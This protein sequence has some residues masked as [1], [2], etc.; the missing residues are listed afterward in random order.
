[1]YLYISDR[2][3]KAI[4]L[5]ADEYAHSNLQ[6]YTSSI[7]YS[8]AVKQKWR[9][10]STM[11]DQQILSQE[12]QLNKELTKEEIVK[13]INHHLQW[14]DLYQFQSGELG[15][16]LSRLLFFS[17]T[18]KETASASTDEQVALQ[19]QSMKDSD[20]Q[21]KKLDVLLKTQEIMHREVLFN[22]QFY[23]FLAGFMALKLKNL[24]DKIK[25][26][27]ELWELGQITEA[28]TDDQF[29]KEKERL[30]LEEE[31][32]KAEEARQ[33]AEAFRLAEEARKQE[34]AKRLAEASEEEKLKMA[35]AKAAEEEFI[36]QQ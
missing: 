17:T 2:V 10:T 23:A 34:E 1:M 13:E 21:E 28:N 14:E 29:L 15:D 25:Q 24:N 27:M 22:V 32:R 4:F 36:R 16:T 12:D 9:N 7:N 6:F 33:R 11:S 5:V 26:V 3:K 35:A 31:A 20:T 30:R 18:T 8:L 19:V